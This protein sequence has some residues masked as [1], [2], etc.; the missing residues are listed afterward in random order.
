MKLLS[1]FRHLRHLNV[2]SVGWEIAK[3]PR[4]RW[5]FSFKTRISI[6]YIYLGFIYELCL[7]NWVD[8]PRKSWKSEINRILNI[9]KCLKATQ[10]S[11]KTV[12]V[13]TYHLQIASRDWS[14]VKSAWWTQRQKGRG[15]T[16]LVVRGG[17]DGPIVVMMIADATIQKS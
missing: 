16:N 2:F 1:I 10:N 12:E 11:E 14:P 5:H 6:I 4:T 17:E 15:D 13:L 7:I 9:R 3:C 8:I